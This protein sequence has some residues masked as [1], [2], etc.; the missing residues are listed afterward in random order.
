M[1]LCGVSTIQVQAYK[2]CTSCNHLKT[3]MAYSVVL[4][5]LQEPPEIS[6]F[7]LSAKAV[8]RQSV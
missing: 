5:P 6:A 3:S 7:V 4:G 8:A 2:L 1:Y